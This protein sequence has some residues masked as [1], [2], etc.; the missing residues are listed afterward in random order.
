VLLHQRRL[1]SFARTGSAQDKQDAKA[2]VD[3][4]VPVF[5]AAKIG[6]R[7]QIVAVA[8]AAQCG[9]GLLDRFGVFGGVVEGGVE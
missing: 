8:A 9:R 1:R 5:Q 4:R 3:G 6:S 2:T 7:L